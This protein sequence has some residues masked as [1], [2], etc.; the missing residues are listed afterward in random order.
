M[1]GMSVLSAFSQIT[2][3]DTQGISIQA[4]AHGVLRSRF[5][6]PSKDR[7]VK[8]ERRI[9]TG[10]RSGYFCL[11]RSASALRFS[12]NDNNERVS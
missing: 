9:R 6:D 1:V 8:I 7:V 11:I 3:N 2:Y 4:P 12:V 5:G 10:M